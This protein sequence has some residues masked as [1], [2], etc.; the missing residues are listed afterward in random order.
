MILQQVQDERKTA[1]PNNRTPGNYCQLAW[2]CYPFSLFRFT[3]TGR[4]RRSPYDDGL[5]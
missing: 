1:R 4:G 5:Q 2:L 3:I